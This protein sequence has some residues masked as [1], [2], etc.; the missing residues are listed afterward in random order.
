MVL[1]KKKKREREVRQNLQRW[2]VEGEHLMETNKNLEEVSKGSQ[3]WWVTPE[4]SLSSKQ[5]SVGQRKARVGHSR[6][7]TKKQGHL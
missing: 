3:L 4:L 5:H 6:L 1:R 7:K 2:G